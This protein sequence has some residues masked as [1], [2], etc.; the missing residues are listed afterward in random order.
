MTAIEHNRILAIAYGAFAA[1]YAFTILLLMVVSFGTFVALGIS[2]ANEAQDNHQAGIGIIGGLFAIVFYSLLGAMF[3]LPTA[4]AAWKLWKHRRSARIWG[5]IA[6]IL[7]APIM[8]LG[9]LIAIY[10]FWFL[11]S[12]EGKRFYSSV[13]DSRAIPALP[14]S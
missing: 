1:L 8:P 11:F 12:S 2:L 13:D 14:T 7:V 6:A 4:L 5:I 10:G 3:V 9:T